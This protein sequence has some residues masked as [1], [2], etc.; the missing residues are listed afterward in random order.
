M[1]L[2]LQKNIKND[3]YLRR[4][5]FQLAK[6]TFDLSFEQW[7]QNGYWTDSYI[8]YVLHENGTV[9]ANA[10]VN[11]IDT[12][13]QGEK[14]RYIQLGTVMTETAYRNRGYSR[15]LIEEILSDWIINCDAIYLYAN[16][17]VLDFYP[18][19]GFIQANEYQ[20]SQTVT[21]KKAGHFQKLSMSE[22][23][24]RE[25]LKRYYE[26]SNPYSALPLIDNFGLVMFYCTTVFKNCVYYSDKYHAVAIANAVGTDLTLI[27]IFCEDTKVDLA[28][29]T[30]ALALPETTNIIYGFTPK[31][32]NTCTVQQL[33]EE[34]TT[35][36]ILQRKENIFAGNQI[37]F[38]ILS[39]A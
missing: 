19:F 26:K 22:S 34:D 15:F 16:D 8:P 11:I 38:P 3:S 20:Y 23:Q 13:W 18:K 36:F 29:I 35:L 10:S 28:E 9:V 32:V 27:D 21:S 7:Y 33:T 2:K 30:A 37:M 12:L 6:N 1:N 39:H 25:L 24:N 14:K 4:S 17:T 31:S 5:F